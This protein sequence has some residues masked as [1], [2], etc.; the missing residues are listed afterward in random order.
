MGRKITTTRG[1]DLYDFWNS[2]IAEQLN[3]ELQN[4]DYSIVI[5]LASNEYFKAVDKKALNRTVISPVFKEE[6][7]GQ[8]RI[9]SVF[10]KLARGLMAR[11]IIQNK[12]DN[13]SDLQ[14]FD[15]S[16][17]RLCADGS[18]PDKPLFVRPQP[19]KKAG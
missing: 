18:T 13:P 11:W 14:N 2:Q 10:A 15:I 7:D 1:E 16:G 6:K 3:K 4:H 9:L 17:Y 8:Q 5:N 12:I 19:Q